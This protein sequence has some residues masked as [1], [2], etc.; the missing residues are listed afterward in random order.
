MWSIGATGKETRIIGYQRSSENERKGVQDSGETMKPVRFRDSG[1]EEK[2]GGWAGGGRAEDVEVFSW[3][4][5]DVYIQEEGQLMWDVS[6]LGRSGW[7]CLGMFRR[8]IAMLRLRQ[9]V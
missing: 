8:G 1:F 4:D 3:C 7:D 6:D 2:T 9:K 5:Q